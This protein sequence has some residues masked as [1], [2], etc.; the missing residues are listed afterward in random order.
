LIP[1]GEPLD[2]AVDHPVLLFGAI[3]SAI[4]RRPCRGTCEPWRRAPEC[5]AITIPRAHDRGL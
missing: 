5:K 2:P 4:G 3:R 1:G